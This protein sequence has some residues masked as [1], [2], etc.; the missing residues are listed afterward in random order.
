MGVPLYVFCCFSLVAYNILSLSLIFVS[1][2]TMCLGVRHLL[3]FIFPG[4]LCASWTWLTI[5]FPMFRKFLAIISS[6]IF[7][8][9]FFSVSF[10]DANIGA[11]NCPQVVQ[12]SCSL[13]SFV[14][15]L[16]SIFCSAAGI[17]TI[18]SSLYPFFSLSYSAV[19]SF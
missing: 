2:I 16:F 8:S 1:L 10:W 15:I 11:F 7:S 6:N 17:S 14:F 3:E 9:P 4:T 13:S 5:S 18:L 12:R 19:N